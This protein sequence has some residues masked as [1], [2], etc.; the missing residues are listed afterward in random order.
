MKNQ[1]NRKFQDKIRESIKSGMPI[2]EVIEELHKNQLTIIQS[3][4]FMIYIMFYF[5]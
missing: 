4:K 5:L 2:E 3:M 1:D